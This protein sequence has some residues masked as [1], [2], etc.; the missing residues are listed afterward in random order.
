MLKIFWFFAKKPD[1]VEKTFSWNITNW[2][3]FYSKFATFSDF[4]KKN[5]DFSSKSQK[6][7]L[8]LQK[9]PKFWTSW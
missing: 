3:A 7:H 8:F 2:D 1:K 6:A 5:Q 4:E 9:R